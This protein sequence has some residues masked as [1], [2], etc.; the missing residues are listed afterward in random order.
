MEIAEN[1]KTYKKLKDGVQTII[2]TSYTNNSLGIHMPSFQPYIPKEDDY[3]NVPAIISYM[4]SKKIIENS[5][6]TKFEYDYFDGINIT[7]SFSDIKNFLTIWQFLKTE[8]LV[9]EVDKKVRKEDYEPFFE[10][11]PIIETAYGKK[12]ANIINTDDSDLLI[13][14]KAY[15]KV[16]TPLLLNIDTSNIKDFRDYISYNFEYSK[17]NELIC[18]QFI[19]KQIYGNSELDVFIR[20]KFK[21]NE[22]INVN[23]TLVPAYLALILTLGITLWQNCFSDT[24]EI[25]AIQ[26]QLTEIQQILANSP[27]TDL[28]SIEEKLEDIKTLSD[29]AYINEKLNEILQEIQL[30]TEPKK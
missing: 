20:K 17:S 6:S 23:K 2:P 29:N 15:K 14:G 8:G 12:K 19:D 21:T 4:G 30:E 9:L 22:Q 27:H 26:E 16:N 13:N 10:Y 25:T 28:T 11:K 7:N 24:S 1:G 18:S 3:E 5:E